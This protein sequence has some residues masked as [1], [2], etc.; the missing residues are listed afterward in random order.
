MAGMIESMSRKSNCWDNAPAESC[1]GAPKTELAQQACYPAREAA[2]RGLFA[3]IEGYSNRQRR[4]PNEEREELRLT[5][6]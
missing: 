3:S 5:A 1:F 2:R 6:F 4:A